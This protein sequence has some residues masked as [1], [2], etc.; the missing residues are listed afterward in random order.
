MSNTNYVN[1]ETLTN[2]VNVYSVQSQNIVELMNTLASMNGELEQGW[3][4][5]TARA[6]IE[7]YDST[8]KP[9]LQATAEALMD[10]SNYIQNYMD[11]RQ[12]EDSAGAAGIRG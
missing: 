3:Q 2:G 7:M 10:I 6:F 9:A 5:E 8:H 1:Y 12:S 4:N 11:A